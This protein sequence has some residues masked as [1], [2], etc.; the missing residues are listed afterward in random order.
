MRQIPGAKMGPGVSAAHRIIREAVPYQAGDAWWG[1][2]IEQVHKLVSNG[3]L[4]QGVRQV[5]DIT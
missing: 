4:M 5:V 1:P 3:I 2:E